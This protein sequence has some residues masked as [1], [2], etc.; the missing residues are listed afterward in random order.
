MVN[1]TLETFVDKLNLG[2]CLNTIF[3]KLHF[4]KS[5]F[6]ETIYLSLYTAIRPCGHSRQ[7][8]PQ[9]TYGHAIFS[10]L[11]SPKMCHKKLENRCNNKI[12]MPKN[13]LGIGTL[14]VQGR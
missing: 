7:E 12:I 5:H 1:L 14:H 9:V 4:A 10:Q 3:Q 6:S 8:T 11:M 13:H 2:Y